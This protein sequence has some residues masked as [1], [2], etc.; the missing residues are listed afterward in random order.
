MP[1]DYMKVALDP[2]EVCTSC[3]NFSFLGEH[4]KARAVASRAAN[5]IFPEPHRGLL[6]PFGGQGLKVLKMSLLGAS[7]GHLAAKA[8]K[9]SKSASWEPPGAIWRPRHQNA[10]NEPPGGLLEPFGGQGTEMLKMSF[11]E[12]SWSYLAARA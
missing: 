4:G 2:T 7:W 5:S 9:C 10:Q 3:T 8:P 12:A 1:S 11:L 6:E